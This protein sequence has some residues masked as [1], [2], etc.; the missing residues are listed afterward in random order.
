MANWSTRVVASAF[1][2][3]AV[4]AA[5]LVLGGMTQ[6]SKVIGFLDVF[7]DWDP[8]LAF[9]M[10][11][12]IGVN[13]P[14]TWWL[15]KRN[16]PLLA[17]SFSIPVSSAPWRS[18]IDARLVGGAVLFGVGWGLA[19]YCPGP[20]IVSLPSALSSGASRDA[21]LFGVAM[22]T[23]MTLFS[24][25]DRHRARVAKI[26]GQPCCEPTSVQGTLPGADGATI[27]GNR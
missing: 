13:A 5:G 1:L 2:S 18:Q 26:A 9:V 10:L 14:L 7:G 6:P 22:V 20:A 16:A 24:V 3:G 11:G 27:T 25:Y 19:G 15:R 4:F 17:P 8:S 21:L 12:A 23:G